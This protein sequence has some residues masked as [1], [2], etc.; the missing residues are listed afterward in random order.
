MWIK[1]LTKIF[2]DFFIAVARWMDG[3]LFFR[4]LTAVFNF[5]KYICTDSFITRAFIADTAP[6]DNSIRRSF[7]G[8]ALDKFLNGLPKPITPP[9]HW[10][11]TMS[12]AFSGSW[13]IGTLCKT[14]D[15]PIPKPGNPD[16]I[17]V[18]FQWALFAAPV[19]GLV[20]VMFAVPFLPTMVLAGILVPVLLLALLSRNFAIDSFAVFLVI[21][22]FVSVLAAV[23]SVA[24][25][26]SIEVVLLTSVFMVSSITIVACFTTSKSVELLIKIFVI[27]AALTGVYGIYQVLFGYQGNVWLDPTLFAGTRLRVFST[28]DNPNVY[29]T[30]LLLAIPLAAACI[31]YLKGVFPKLCAVGITGLLVVNLFLTLS[32]GCYLSLALAVAV[33]VLIIEKR[34]LLPL[35]PMA[36]ALPFVLPATI[37]N[38]FMSIFN[39]DDTSTAFRLN[40]WRGSLR[41]LQDFWVGGIGQGIE[42][43]D[44]VYPFYALSAIHSPHSHSLYFQYFIEVGVFGFAVFIIVLACYFRIMSNFIRRTTNFKNRIMAAAMVAAVIGFLFQGITDFVFYN[45]RVALTF[46]LFIGISLAFTKVN[47]EIPKPDEQPPLIKNYYD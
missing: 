10:H 11:K 46:Y 35:I 42:A 43:Y 44:R 31:V 24:L 9:E 17:Y 33:F 6:L 8:R 22:I 47:A 38:R 12:N 21:F 27:S 18:V 36:A 23:F 30:Y 3:S 7:V 25:R 1:L 34:L 15:S 26:S 39:M 20:A 41:I 2:L 4:G 14:I 16:G 28:F 29:G 32:R 19:L 45:F 13:L 37:I 5:F 40:I